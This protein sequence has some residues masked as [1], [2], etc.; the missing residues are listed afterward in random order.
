MLIVG[1]N[2]HEIDK[3]KKKLSKEFSMNDLYATKQILG[4]RITKDR[5]VLKLSQEEYVKKMLSR[6]NMVGVTPMSTL[7]ASHFHLSKDQS[8]LNEQEWVYM[9]KVSC[10]FAIDNLMYA[11][12]YTRL[13][14]AHAMGVVSKYM[15]NL[16]N[17]T[18]RQ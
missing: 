18:R 12:I 15:S 2:I 16:G 3:L 7:L 9:A 4:M 5:D 14:I 13:D 17:N 11:M 6:S 8:P 10:V 1:A